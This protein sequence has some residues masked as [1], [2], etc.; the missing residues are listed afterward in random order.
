MLNDRI[1]LSRSELAEIEKAAAA[2]GIEARPFRVTQKGGNYPFWQ[3]EELRSGYWT[4][5]IDWDWKKRRVRFHRR[6]VERLLAA[7]LVVD[8]E[9]G[10]GKNCSVEYKYLKAAL[11][12]CSA[13]SR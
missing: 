11:G 8:T 9:R 13:E 5:V 1:G 2:Y 6:F 10:A 12:L 4:F 7:G 3:T